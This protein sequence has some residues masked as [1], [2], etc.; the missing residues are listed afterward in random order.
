MARKVWWVMASGLLS[1]VFGGPNHIGAQ[2]P[3][4]AT[5]EKSQATSQ[6]EAT[7]P[8]TVK[9]VGAELAALKAQVQT[10]ESKL[11][12][13]RGKVVQVEPAEEI[14]R[15]TEWVCERGHVFSAP[16][17]QGRCP[18][19]QTPI[20]SREQY[21]KVKLARRQ[22]LPEI[23]EARLEEQSRQR[24]AVGVSATGIIQ[25]TAGAGP[26][27]LRGEGSFDVLLT[28][29]P[30]STRS[31]SQMWKRSG[32]TVPIR[33]PARYLVLTRTRDPSRTRTGQTE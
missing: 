4:S 28:A 27:R 8:Q 33:L 16:P 5:A 14:K 10:L 24:V 25:Q 20:V 13:L 6:E 18:Y 15:V 26:N 11:E 31:F 32:A 22:T 9:A 7:L 21:R 19:D 2:G 12:E 17:E 1:S 23:V 30:P 3:E 29:P